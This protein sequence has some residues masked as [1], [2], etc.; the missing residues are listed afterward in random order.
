MTTDNEN[1]TE[2]VQYS[3][4]ETLKRQDRQP[5]A[6]VI[7]VKQQQSSVDKEKAI[8]NFAAQF[9]ITLFGNALVQPDVVSNL[10]SCWQAACNRAEILAEKLAVTGITPDYKLMERLL[11]AAQG[12]NEP[13]SKY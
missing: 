7:R 3:F 6:A 13:P 11:N 8:A 10:E 2:Q 4:I 12:I 5:P 9:A 1:T